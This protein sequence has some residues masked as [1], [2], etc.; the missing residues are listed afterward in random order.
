MLNVNV[1]ER[2]TMSKYKNVISDEEKKA[3]LESA[4]ETE[5]GRAAL[6]KSLEKKAEDIQKMMGYR[7]LGQRLLTLCEATDNEF[8]HFSGESPHFY[9]VNPV[10]ESLQKFEVPKDL[11]IMMEDFP[12]VYFHKSFNYSTKRKLHPAII[13][14][15]SY[16][17]VEALSYVTNEFVSNA[18]LSALE[19]RTNKIK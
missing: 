9:A 4:M 3:I 7:S 12:S 19:F 11:Y 16:R 6:A 13:D 2:N 17:C 8:V 5:E 14:T 18:L 10:N 1:V 15:L